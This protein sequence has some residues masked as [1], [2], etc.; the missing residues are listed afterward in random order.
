V[1]GVVCL[2][3]EGLG[4][5]DFLENREGEF[6]TVAAFLKNKMEFISPKSYESEI[7]QVPKDFY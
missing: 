6:S 4:L 3:I 1:K 5:R 7:P 2:I